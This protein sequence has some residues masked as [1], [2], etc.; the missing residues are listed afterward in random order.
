M[1]Y[2]RFSSDAFRSNVYVYENMDGNFIINVAE[3]KMDC[4]EH[5][6]PAPVESLNPNYMSGEEITEQ[7]NRILEF[8][9]ECPRKPING[10]FDGDMIVCEDLESTKDQLLQLREH[11]YHVPEYTFE[12][13]DEELEDET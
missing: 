12:I 2:C 13:I 1:S 8:V 9:D 3:N 7:W 5:E 11:G 6:I 10:G 4:E